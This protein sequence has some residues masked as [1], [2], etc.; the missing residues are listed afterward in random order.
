MR[1]GDIPDVR[2]GLVPSKRCSSFKRSHETYFA[3]GS[4]SE[5]EKFFTVH[6]ENLIPWPEVL[7]K[8]I[9]ICHGWIQSKKAKSRLCLGETTMELYLLCLS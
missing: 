6:L 2:T 1:W 3:R 5:D 7:A 9:P 8:H 4:K